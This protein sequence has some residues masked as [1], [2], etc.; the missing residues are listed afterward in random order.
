MVGTKKTMSA[1]LYSRFTSKTITV[2][3][4]PNP[5]NIPNTSIMKRNSATTSEPTNAPPSQGL[6]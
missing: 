1:C 5:G 4:V 6:A 3:T 2:A